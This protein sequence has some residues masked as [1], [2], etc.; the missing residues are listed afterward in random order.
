[1][2]KVLGRLGLT[3]RAARLANPDLQ[4]TVSPFL[5]HKHTSFF[6]AWLFTFSTN[7]S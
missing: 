4:H 6:C 7:T 1:M 3:A 2:R 5:R